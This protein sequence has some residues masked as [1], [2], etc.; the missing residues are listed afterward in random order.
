MSSSKRPSGWLYVLGIVLTFGG[1][2][3]SCG[4]T[5]WQSSKRVDGLQRVVMPGAHEV[6]LSPGEY[7]LYAESRSTVNGTAYLWHGGALQC[8]LAES[9]SNQ[10]VPL[11]G[12]SVNESYSFGSYEGQ[13]MFSFEIPS[14]G[15]YR[16]ACDVETGGPMV[17]S[18]SHGHVLGSML[19]SMLAGFLVAAGGLTMILLT[20]DKRRQRHPA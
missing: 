14:A 16:L 17:L 12:A 11:S 20:W 5:L 8:Q 2:G 18:L 3:A 1:C 19:Y 4:V 7:V 15:R 13:S 9:A 10:P 6:E